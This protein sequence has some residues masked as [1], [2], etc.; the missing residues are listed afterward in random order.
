MRTTTLTTTTLANS[1]REAREFVGNGAVS[2]N[3]VRAEA[4]R[5]LTA[6]DL[7]HGNSILFRR[8]KKKWHATR[9]Q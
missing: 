1:K 6:D 4:D 9:W 8:G 3:G 7:L 2:V 5:V